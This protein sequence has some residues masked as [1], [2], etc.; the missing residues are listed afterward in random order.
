MVPRLLLAGDQQVAYG[1]I[2]LFPLAATVM[3]QHLRPE[4]Q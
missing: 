2:P 3:V 1:G 4:Y